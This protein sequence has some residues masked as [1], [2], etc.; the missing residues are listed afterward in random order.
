MGMK[1]GIVQLLVEGA[2]PGRNLERASKYIEKAV[3]SKVDMI[4]LPETIDFGWTHPE[5]L[6]NAE[7]IPGEY[8]QMFCDLAKKNSIWICVGLTEKLNDLNYNTAIL[9]NRIGEIVLK[10]RKINLLEVEFPFYQI[11]NKIE[12]INTEFGTIGLNICAD[13]Y[14]GSK[15]LGESLAAM[16]ANLILSPS[17]WTVDHAVNEADDPYEDKWIN[18]YLYLARNF[19]LIVASTTSVGYLVGGPYIGKKMMGNSLVVG[20]N[21]II[22]QGVLNEFSSH[23]VLV[24]LQLSKSNLKGVQI[25]ARLNKTNEQNR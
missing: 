1:L 6:R 5:S 14:W 10:H 8:S 20:P 23:L 24:D 22:E 16:G 3:A 21:G 2:E 7:P 17:S 11:G 13:N 12:V 18:P 4:L 25:G 15:Y 19:N 9:I